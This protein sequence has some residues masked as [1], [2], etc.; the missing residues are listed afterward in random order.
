MAYYGAGIRMIG[1]SQLLLEEDAV[2]KIFNNEVYVRGGGFF[3]MDECTI[4]H[5]PSNT[6]S[7]FFQFVHRNGTLVNRSFIHGINTSVVMDRNSQ[8][9]SGYNEAVMIFNSNI[10]QCF[11]LDDTDLTDVG[12]TTSL[13]D[14]VPRKSNTEIFQA[15]FNLTKGHTYT[16]REI[17]SIPRKIC[18]CGENGVIITCDLASQQPLRYYPGQRLKVNI[19]LL[20][21]MD[22]PLNSILYID[23]DRDTQLNDTEIFVPLNLHSIHILESKCNELI[24]PPLPK[25]RTIKKQK[26]TTT[27]NRTATIYLRLRVSVLHDTFMQETDIMY[28]TGVIKTEQHI[29]PICPDGFLLI[30]HACQCHPK[31]IQHGFNCSLDE[32]AFILPQNQSAWI[33]K[34]TE[35]SVNQYQLSWSLHCPYIYCHS[36]TLTQVHID[37]Y[38][39]QCKYNRIGVLCGQC[40]RHHSVVF[41]S[42]KCEICNNWSLLILIVPLIAGPILVIIIGVLNITIS[43]G[44]I[45]GYMFYITIVTVIC[46]FNFEFLSELTICLYDGMDEFGKTLTAYVIPLYLLLLVVIACCLPRC[47]RINMHKINKK[48]GPRITPVLA[49]IITLSYLFTFYTVIKSFQPAQVYSVDGRVTYVWLHDGSLK[50]F[51][52]IKHIILGCIAITMFLFLLLPAALTAT[53]GDLFRRFIK[54]PWYLNFLDT[55]HGAFRFRFGFWFGVRLLILTVIMILKVL[56][57]PKN[58]QLAVVCMS[59][60][61][62]L[63]QMI[64]QPYRGMRIKECVTRAVKEKYFSERMQRIITNLLDNLF[65]INLMVFFAWI[66]YSPHS[67][68]AALGTSLA[69]AHME[70]VIIIIYHLLEYTPLGQLVIDLRIATRIRYNRWKEARL[71][72]AIRNRNKPQEEPDSVQT[73]EFE[74]RLED[75][76]NDDGIDDDDDDGDS[77][78]NSESNQSD[79]NTN[80]GDNSNAV[81][82]KSDKNDKHSVSTKQADISHSDPLQTPLLSKNTPCT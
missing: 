62:L 77:D 22:I 21:D 8:I 14:I 73:V 79:G 28:L 66:L 39:V 19:V 20:G 70:F 59:T 74:L 7:C 63:F 4:Y 6:C 25:S 3:I 75:C 64:V 53:F 42:V 32:L 81:T 34:M 16:S 11:F 45:N 9:D 33:G 76:W 26:N 50:Y 24:I 38:H 46:D 29:N 12:N 61:I 36:S 58:V 82:E 35:S 71:L 52:C 10:D 67:P 57:E 44:P 56:V 15:V 37:N 13:H 41:F 43:V 31:L 1:D 72:R 2:L 48:I 5:W 60:I 55:F 40:P 68:T 17:S 54:G 51:Q 65:Q 27:T 69:I 23:L 49:T 47:R 30:Q 78:D 80:S 18:M